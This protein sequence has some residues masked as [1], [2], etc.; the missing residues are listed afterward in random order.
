MNP[1]P[2]LA[3]VLL[4]TFGLAGLLLSGLLA[5]LWRVRLGRT[6]AAPLDLLGLRLLP[7]AGGALVA[8][9]AALPAF[10]RYEPHGQHE[11]AGPVLIGLAALAVACLAHGLWRAWRAC[12]ATHALVLRWGLERPR[13][14][15]PSPAVHVVD[16]AEPVVAVVGAWHPRIVAAE[17]VRAACDPEEFRGIVAHE[18]AHVAA[19][20]NLKLL[21]LIAAPD[22]LAWT[23]LAATLTARWRAAAERAADQSSTGAD[24]RRRLALAS[25]L[26]KVARLFGCADPGCPA[27]SMAVAADDI[28]GRVLRL[29]GPPALPVRAAILRALVAGGL[30]ILLGAL[31]RYA[32]LHELLEQLVG[33]GR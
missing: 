24:P 26:I 16:L 5:L 31:P 33:L 11:A 29:L 8:L 17:S 20:D 25:A 1:A 32:L 27:L 21:L 23:P 3:L 6:A 7:A 9:T 15:A 19:R 30:L 22:V 4:A 28:P 14:G 18:A 12:R 10:L 13:G 2:L